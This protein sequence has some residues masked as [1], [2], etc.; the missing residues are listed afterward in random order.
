MRKR[1]LVTGALIALV[2][3]NSGCVIQPLQPEDALVSK[4]IDLEIK[5]AMAKDTAAQL[6]RLFAMGKTTL[7][8]EQSSEDGF[9]TE[10]KKLLRQQGFAVKERMP[11]ESPA[12]NLSSSPP[13]T[14]I[15]STTETATEPGVPISY[16]VDG[17][18]DF[19]YV[20]LRAGEQNLT[21][22]YVFTNS[23]V[24]PAGH[25]VKKEQR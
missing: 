16:T 17:S 21:R 2:L 25:W 1:S 4:N 5:Q 22:T 7:D 14:D 3:L 6:S 13:T 12:F 15:A 10:L 23:E 24:V 18:S 9:S 19:Y 8:F 20:H 11:K